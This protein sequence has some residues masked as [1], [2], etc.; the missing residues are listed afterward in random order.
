M[1]IT[2]LSPAEPGRE[3][4]WLGPI[5]F[6]VMAMGFAWLVALPLFFTGGLRSPLFLPLS[7]LM[8]LTP[9]LSALLVSRYF[10]GFQNPW[11]Q[12]G[13]WPLRPVGRLIAYVAIALVGMILIVL[14]ALPI[15]SL[16]GV[17][18]AD[19]QNFSG[20]QEAMR[21]SLEQQGS[22]GEVPIEGL[23]GAQ[24]VGAFIGAFV[25][26]VPAAGSELGWRGYLFPRVFRRFGA[27]PAI[28]TTG[29][30]WGLWYSPL[31]VLGYNYEHTGPLVSILLMIVFCVII[32]ALLSWVR[33]RSDSVWPAVIGQGA[34]A[35]AMG[36]GAMNASV[37]F[38]YVFLEAG[39][40]VDTTQATVLGWSG[41]IVPLILIVILVL[42]GGFRPVRSA[43][44]PEAPARTPIPAPVQDAPRAELPAEPEPKSEF[45]AQP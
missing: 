12:L 19:F 5:L 39:Q 38:S 32:G 16:F 10:E 45:P 20:Y 33:L 6:V 28:L 17:Y 31:L 27:I 26:I 40:T 9:G 42:L 8:M 34:L 23:V 41:W 18:H 11:P 1:S 4:P 3:R 30:L 13:A 43:T 7:I 25:N 24:F 2:P 15:G 37:G 21:V 35:S 36:V 14:V 29:V 44:V 22:L